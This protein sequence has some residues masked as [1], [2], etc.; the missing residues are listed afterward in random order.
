MFKAYKKPPPDARIIKMRAYEDNNKNLRD[1]VK[2][3]AEVHERAHWENRTDEVIQRNVIMKKYETL[4]QE[5]RGA[6]EARR[7]RLAE[8]LYFEER[9]L[10]EELQKSQVTGDQRREQMVARA[11]A[12]YEER[13]QERKI[14][15]EEAMY[16]AW[17]EGCDPLRL[18]LM[19]KVVIN[20]VEERNLQ[21]AEKQNRLETEKEE[22]RQFDAMY[23]RER[24][25]KEQR[26]LEDKQRRKELEHQAIKVLT[27]QQASNQ[28]R[29][30]EQAAQLDREAQEMKQKWAAEEVQARR[31]AEAKQAANR[32]MGEELLRLNIEMQEQR[33]SELAKEREE[34]FA[35][36]QA[37]L[38]KAKQEE[39]RE[40]EQRLRL[41]DEA[42]VFR[43]H[44]LVQMQHEAEDTADRDRLIQDAED[45]HVR[46]REEEDERN[47]EARR[48]L[49]DEVLVTREA[50]IQEKMELS[51][52]A[53]QERAYEREKLKSEMDR[54]AKQE[55]EY[56]HMVRM[57]RVQN[58]MDIE[59]QIRQKENLKAKA[60]MEQVRAHE[61]AMAA[62][63]MYQTMIANH[64]EEPS[65]W[66]GRKAT[67][68][69]D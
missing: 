1:H 26:Y 13:E 63:G 9:Y 56:T 57:Q 54:I 48:R 24:V 25:K 23:E 5:A 28:E 41:A 58:Q 33:A 35:L 37:A 50:Q 52:L 39:D 30:A 8:K 67:K 34:N 62:E 66:F 38:V 14:Q 43:E 19:K 65:R 6:L 7:A 46:K 29:R 51:A 61:G 4:M 69:Y 2:M 64:Q 21:L 59:A 53:A 47:Q 40:S 3:N 32:K 49:L 12:L 45:A 42:R 22:K 20:T 36:V 27:E 68:W 10:Q 55:E 16:A 11:K 17:R 15:A 60:K 31:E 44:L 18:E